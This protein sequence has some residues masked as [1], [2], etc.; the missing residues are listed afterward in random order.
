V[1]QVLPKI[2]KIVVENVNSHTRFERSKKAG[3]PGKKISF[4][5]PFPVSKAM[6][7]D[8]SSGESSRVGY[9]FLENGNKQ[10]IA[11]VSGKAV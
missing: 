6:L 9:K 7:V 5:A 10:R 11:K 1:L 4:F 2:G 3:A 8:G